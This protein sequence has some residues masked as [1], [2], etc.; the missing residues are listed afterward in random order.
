MQFDHF[1]AGGRMS[2]LDEI[3]EMLDK[4]TDAIAKHDSNP[5]SWLMWNIYLLK[6]LEQKSRSVDPMDQ[7]LFTEMI[8][9]L[10][11]TIRNRL[12]TGGW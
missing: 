10:R 3:R 11:D 5:S 1:P 4:I 12:N 8:A 2:D 7:K 9:N 6:N